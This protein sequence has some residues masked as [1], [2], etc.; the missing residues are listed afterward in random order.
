MHVGCPGDKTISKTH[1]GRG[2]YPTECLVDLSKG[3]PTSGHLFKELCAGTT[4]APKESHKMQDWDRWRGKIF[5]CN[6]PINKA[7]GDKL[8]S[9]K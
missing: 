6:A 3:P 2:N 4:L 5:K 9:M 8:L 7:L 1:P